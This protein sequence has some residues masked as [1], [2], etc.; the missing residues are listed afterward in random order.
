MSTFNQS[1]NNACEHDYCSVCAEQLGPYSYSS[2]TDSEGEEVRM[3]NYERPYILAELARGETFICESCYQ[4]G[5][6]DRLG[7]EE[8]F[9]INYEF[10]LEYANFGDFEMSRR[11]L[12]KAAAIN[13]CADVLVSL[14]RAYGACGNKEKEIRLL[15]EAYKNNREHIVSIHNLIVCLVQNKKYPEALK[16]VD[17]CFGRI[18]HDDQLLMWMAEIY[19]H[20]KER[21]LAFEFFER[22]RSIAH[23]ETCASEF[24]VWWD[25][26]QQQSEWH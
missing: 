18:G 26:L 15:Q 11:C 17:Q 7:Y 2:W 6:C 1:K 9:Q 16:I 25:S 14:A 5:C 23:C 12:E 19:Y 24:D 10:G 8:K 3:P 13:R 20:R 22:A 4:N 21:E